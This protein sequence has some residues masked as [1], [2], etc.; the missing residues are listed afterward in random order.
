VTIELLY[1]VSH[2]IQYQAPL[3]RQISMDPGIN[4]TVIFEND[5]SSGDYFDEGFGVDVEWD[6]PLRDG[7]HNVL[8]EDIDPAKYIKEAD[9]VWF[10]G[11]QSRQFRRLMRQARSIGTPVLLRGENWAGA[12]P[13]GWGLRGWLKR[14]Y[15]R[16]IFLNCS[17]YL[18]VGRVNRAYYLAHSISEDKIFHMPY[19]VDNSFFNVRA[20]TEAGLNFR[21]ELG[22]EDQQKIVLFAGK[23]TARKKPDILLEAWE[24]A[25]WSA[26][27]RPAL[28]YVGDGQLKQSL[29]TATERSRY[30]DDIYFTGF[31]NQTELPGVYRAADVFVLASEKEPWGLGINEAMASGAA[32]IASD[33]CGAAFDLISEKTGVMVSAGNS[34]ELATALG[35]VLKRSDDMGQAAKIQISNWDFDADITG[36]KHALDFVR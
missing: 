12:M 35:A 10:H 16:N 14:L 21:R 25:D 34:N 28:V 6:I 13:D 32:V 15:L 18:A 29:L 23:F 8:L 27:N 19:A 24:R 3:L 9:A 2:P 31:R 22:I 7:Y 33:Q 1:F 5:F 30:K 11:W 4:L 17:A 26:S 36:L 20:T